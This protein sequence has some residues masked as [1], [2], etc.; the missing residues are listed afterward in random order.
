MVHIIYSALTFGAAAA[1]VM[2]QPKALLVSWAPT[3][4]EAGLLPD[5]VV[6][7]SAGFFA[8]QLWMLVRTRSVMPAAY[9]ILLI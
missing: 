2:R 5:V 1:Y 6:C 3:A 9:V 8:F 4:A 7:M